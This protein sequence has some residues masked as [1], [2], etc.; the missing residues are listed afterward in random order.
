[1]V[2]SLTVSIYTLCC[3]RTKP[4]VGQAGK[5]SACAMDII[6]N[7]LR[8]ITLRSIKK[9][10]FI[11]RFIL[12]T[13]RALKRTIKEFKLIDMAIYKSKALLTT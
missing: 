7:E 4:I 9:L 6:C 1:M 12:K 3:H 8:L 11:I 2:F 13:R 10:A 5:N